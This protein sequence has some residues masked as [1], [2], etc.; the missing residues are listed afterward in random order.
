MQKSAAHPRAPGKARRGQSGPGPESQGFKQP[1]RGPQP[2]GAGPERLCSPRA[3]PA[4]H[5]AGAAVGM[6]LPRCAFV[7]THVCVF[8]YGQGMTHTSVC[9]CVHARTSLAPSGSLHRRVA[10]GE[11]A[12]GPLGATG[13]TPRR[14]GAQWHLKRLLRPS[15]VPP[16][17]KPLFPEAS[18]NAGETGFLF[19]GLC[20]SLGGLSPPAG[21]EDS[22]PLRS[23]PLQAPSWPPFRPLPAAST[24]QGVRGG[25]AGVGRVG[26][27]LVSA[28]LVLAVCES[29]W[30]PPLPAST[31]SLRQGLGG[32]PASPLC[33][34]PGGPLMDGAMGSSHIHLFSRSR[35]VCSATPR[36][37]GSRVKTRGACSC[38]LC[39]QQ[40][41]GNTA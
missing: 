32:R 6:T 9:V 21:Q 23:W 8:L 34:Q 39:L 36:N 41:G 18:A 20:G 2:L 33:S 1:R 26:R 25:R 17:P 30:E 3:G 16:Q 35:K 11:R 7:C 38:L 31:T 10:C 5:L 40:R 22:E 14:P 15:S 24:C 13:L 28:V 29:P 12:R 37:P 4:S 19:P 27:A